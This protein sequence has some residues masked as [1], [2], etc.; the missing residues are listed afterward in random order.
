MRTKTLLGAAAFL[1]ASLLSIGSAHAQRIE[2]FTVQKFEPA[3]RGSEWFGSDSLDFRG[4]LRP[5]VGVVADYSYRSLLLYQRDDDVRASVVRN[6][7]YIH[8]GASLVLFDRIRAA[9][10]VPLQ[11]GVDGHHG[12]VFRNNTNYAYSAPPDCC[13]LG[14]IRLAADARIYGVHG[15][16]FTVAGGL[17][18]WLPTGS[19]DQYAGDGEIR[20]KP[21]VMVA[22]DVGMFTYAASV[23]VNI[24]PRQED[25]PPGA[26]GHELNV[27]A[28]AGVKVLDKNLTVGPETWMSSVF[29]HFFE[30]KE[31]TLEI[32]V[33][34]HYLIANQIRVGL[35]GMGGPTRAFSNPVYRLMAMAEWAPGADEDR[36]GDGIPDR[37][38][39]CPDQKG[40]RSAD[41]AKNGCPEVVVAPVKPTDRDNDG[42][43]DM[44]DACPDVPGVQTS[45][46]ATNGCRD[47]DGDG[48]FDPK[49]ACP[50]EKG[51]PSNDPTLNGCPDT[52]GDG[53]FDKQDACPTEPGPKSD[54]PKKNG[55]PIGDKDKDGIKDDVDACPDEPGPA[56]PDPKRNGCPKAFIS[57]GQIKILDQVKF[58]LNSAAIEPGRDSEEVLEAVLG[59]LKTHPDIKH[60]RIEGHTDK[61]GSA[62]LNKKLS[63][64]RAAT[65]K[66]WLTSHGIDG[67]RL[68]SQGFGPD[69]PIDTNETEAGRKNNRRVEFHI[70]DEPATTAKPAA[71]PAAKPTPTKK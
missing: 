6:Q 51:A 19:Q 64:D 53:I 16:A 21:H 59:V 63:A 56:D 55:C 52:D 42:I 7:V 11:L 2:G 40:V 23:G 45:D 37:E 61:T 68:S 69:K 46:P 13:A 12:S 60:L 41:P 24:R 25:I 70:E 8:P 3:E 62:A 17:Q 22:G 14:D 43:P 33:G 39:A 44:N 66:T 58:K 15:D 27:T 10:S 50:T 5:A 47:T 28:A 38:D 65:V 18:F 71:T 57:Q 26:I 48:I 31:T 35:G 67:K 1:G 4:K 49:D 20:L 32:G 54:D 30:K 36:D 9:V 29:N 34:A